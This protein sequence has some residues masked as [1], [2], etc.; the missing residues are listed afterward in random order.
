MCGYVL[1]FTKKIKFNIY[2]MA[3]ITGLYLFFTDFFYV[4]SSF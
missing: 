3:I 1:S 2:L 4:S